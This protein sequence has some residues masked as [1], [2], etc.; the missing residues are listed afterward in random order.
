MSDAPFLMPRGR[1][2]RIA[3][4]IGDVIDVGLGEILTPVGRVFLSTVRLAALL[5]GMISLWTVATYHG[6]HQADVVGHALVR[7]V[8]LGLLAAGA[9]RLRSRLIPRV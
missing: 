6:P 3:A 2:Q 1:L 7:V 4:G 8:L 5:A 9:A